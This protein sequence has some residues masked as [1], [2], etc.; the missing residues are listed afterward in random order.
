MEQ[1]KRDIYILSDTKIEGVQNL[2]L[3]K[4]KPI[5]LTIDI[6]NFDALIFTSKNGVIHLDKVT[7]SWKEIPS[8]AISKQTA[9]V[10]QDKGG[11]LVFTGKK[12]HG[13]QFA[14]EL[15][16]K[17]Q[18]KSTAFIGAKKVVSDLVDILEKNQIG[19][20][21]IPIYET[22]CVVYKDKLQ[23]SKNSIIIFSSPSTIDCFFKNIDWDKSYQAI[24]IGKTTAKYFPSF[25]N[26]IIA[27]DTSLQ[28]CVQKALSL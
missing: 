10:I 6:S 3:I 8:Y 21:H 27:E 5:A 22:E 14:E 11:N 12:K 17:L 7:K 24:S 25:I 4:T 2:Q 1:S 20:I 18:G 15:I 16:K 9:Q 28:S 26:P 13:D 23:L 19:C